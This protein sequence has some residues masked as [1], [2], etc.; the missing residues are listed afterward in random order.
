MKGDVIQQ[1]KVLSCE[2]AKRAG[3]YGSD[4]R[5]QPALRS[6][7]DTSPS[8][9]GCE[10]SGRNRVNSK[11]VPKGCCGRRPAS[12]AGKAVERVGA[13]AHRTRAVHRDNGGSTTRRIASQH[14][15]ST[16][17]EIKRSSTAPWGLAAVEVGGARSTAEDRETGWREGA[18]VLR[19]FG[20]RR[21]SGRL[22]CA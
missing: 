18:L 9:T 17:V 16:A 4:V 8:W 1:M 22:A 11:K 6:L 15:R 2:L 12:D 10:T 7:P 21:G 20:R 5:G 13:I 3:S 14:G 19:C